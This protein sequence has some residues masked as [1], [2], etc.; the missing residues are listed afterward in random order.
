MKIISTNRVPAS[1]STSRVA[2]VTKGFK[3]QD[4]IERRFLV[5]EI[6]AN[7]LTFPY[8]RITQA[9]LPS[10]NGVSIRIRKV[11]DMDNEITFYQTIKLEKKG[12]GKIREET[13]IE[14][15]EKVYDALLPLAKGNK[16]KKIRFLIPYGAKTIELDIYTGKYIGLVTA[17]VEFKTER[18]CDNFVP[19]NWFGREVTSLNSYTNH[20]LALQGIPYNTPLHNTKNIISKILRNS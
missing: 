17:E 3:F 13:E 1:K 11:T 2:Q 10:E 19:L 5:K 20:C 9:Y 4:E 8:L 16:I 18:E 7:L 15:H 12:V 14:I 6:P